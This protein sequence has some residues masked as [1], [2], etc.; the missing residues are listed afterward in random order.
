MDEKYFIAKITTDMADENTCPFFYLY[1][2]FSV[3][4]PKK[5]FFL[6][7]YIFICKINA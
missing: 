1:M 4:C 7:T 3:N 5:G 2:F 6:K